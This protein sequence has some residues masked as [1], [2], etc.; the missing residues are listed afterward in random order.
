MVFLEILFNNIEQ[1]FLSE[2]KN[3]VS[4]FVA[5]V[6]QHQT[7]FYRLAHW[8]YLNQK[9]NIFFPPHNAR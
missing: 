7:S 2:M 4:K 8:D 1:R 9:D 6:L 3:F 5:S